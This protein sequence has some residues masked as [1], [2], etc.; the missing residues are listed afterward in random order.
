MLGT[1]T[2]IS[3]EHKR[4]S[5]V[6]YCLYVSFSFINKQVKEVKLQ[7]QW[8]RLSPHQTPQSHICPLMLVDLVLELWCEH[9]SQGL[10]STSHLTFRLWLQKTH[11][12]PCTAYRY[13]T[14]LTVYFSHV[15]PWGLFNNSPSSAET[16]KCFLCA[17]SLSTLKQHRP[18]QPAGGWETTEIIQEVF[19]S[20]ILQLCSCSWTANVWWAGDCH[21]I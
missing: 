5:W 17:S 16:L 4:Y 18:S 3:L 6:H 10:S 11:T 13:C 7:L 19:T 1:T 12:M 2:L 9:Q 21:L 15:K 8:H 20:K 14:V